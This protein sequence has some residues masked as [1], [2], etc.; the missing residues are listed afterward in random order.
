[1]VKILIPSRILVISVEAI[2]LKVT[3]KNNNKSMQEL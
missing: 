1:V 3:S 2:N